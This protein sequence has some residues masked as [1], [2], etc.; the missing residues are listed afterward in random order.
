VR[1]RAGRLQVIELGEDAVSAVGPARPL[2]GLA[3]GER[4]TAIDHRLVDGT[5]LAVTDAPALYAVDVDDASATRIGPPAQMPLDVVVESLDVNPTVDLLRYQGASGANRRVDP[6]WGGVRAVDGDLR[7]ADGDPGAGAEPAVTGSAYA[8]NLAGATT[9]TLYVVDSDAD[10]L[11]RQDANAG[12]LTTIGD[13][14]VDLGPG[15]GFDV[16]QDGVAYLAGA[17][18]DGLARVARVDLATGAATTV[19]DLDLGAGGGTVPGEGIAAF[20]VVPE[21]GRLF[22][23]D[24]FAT[25]AQVSRRTVAAPAPVAFVA[26]GASFAD[27]LAGGPP[28]AEAGAPIL[29]VAADRIPDPVRAELQRLQPEEVVVLG[30]PAAVGPAVESELRDLAGAGGVRR[31]SGAD[32]YAT[33]AAIATDAYEPGVPVLHVA[34]GEGFADALAGGAAAAAA[35]G[36]LLLTARDRLPEATADAV[37]ALAPERVVVLGGAAAVSDA[38]LEQLRDLVDG[39]VDRLSGADRFATAAAV[40]RAA[41]PTGADVAV[42]TTGRDFPDALTAVPT[43]GARPGPVLL[44][45]PAVIPSATSAVLADLPFGYVRVVGGRVAVSEDVERALAVRPRPGT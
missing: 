8:N 17:V 34:T 11:A 35:D 9:T 5:L 33:A 36:P 2:T 38:V 20:A 3:A 41:F 25:S 10:V 18:D 22:G 37:E 13:L 30:G 1:G 43:T 21:V 6:D 4:V 12:V 16:G 29:L 27:A 40:A 45:E 26:S 7:Y 31:L 32:R 24:R 44:V 28:A 23:T 19:G 42:V 39:E 15:N 14:G